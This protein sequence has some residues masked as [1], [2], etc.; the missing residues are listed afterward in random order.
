MP[1]SVGAAMSYVEG[2]FGGPVTEDDI[3]LSL[4][5]GVVTRAVENDPER[6][7]LTVINLGTNDVYMALDET[8]S[9]TYGIGVFASGGFA[10]FNVRDDQ[11]LPTREWWVISPNGAT[12][13]YILYTRRYALET[14]NYLVPPPAA[15]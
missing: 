12:D 6:L 2:I 8:V 3:P 14:A 5:S 1:P 10:S 13:L 9:S 7:S 11:L 4:S 15:G